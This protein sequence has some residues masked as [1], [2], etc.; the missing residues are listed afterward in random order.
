[1]SKMRQNL[2]W[3]TG[4]NDAAIPIVAGVLSPWGI[5]LRLER[6]VL[7]MSASLIIVVVNALLLRRKRL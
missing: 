3:A 5:T 7:I 6:G 2:F 4:Y 1:M